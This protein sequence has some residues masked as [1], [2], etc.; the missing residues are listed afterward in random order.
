MLVCLL[1]LAN[2]TNQPGG[3]KK[4]NRRHLPP[5]LSNISARA[6]ARCLSVALASSTRTTLGGHPHNVCR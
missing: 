4:K 6:I 2:Q 5:I 3:R 1:G